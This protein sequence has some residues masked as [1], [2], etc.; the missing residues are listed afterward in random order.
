MEKGRRFRAFTAFAEA[1]TVAHNY[2]QLQF[3]GSDASSGSH[4]LL[5]ARIDTHAYTHKIK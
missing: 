3:E 5:Y 2:L 4:K 1:H